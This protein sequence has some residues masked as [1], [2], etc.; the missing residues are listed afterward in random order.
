SGGA[1]DLEGQR[2]D[3]GR[4]HGQ[5]GQDVVVGVGTG[6]GQRDDDAAAG[7]VA[8]L[9]GVARRQPQVAVED[10]ELARDVGVD[11]DVV[12]GDERGRVER[13][14]DGGSRRAVVGLVGEGEA[15]EAD[16]ARLDRERGGRGA[17][18]AAAGRDGHQVDADV[19]GCVGERGRVVGREV[20]VGG[21]F[22]GGRVGEVGGDGLRLAVVSDD[23]VFHDDGDEGDGHG[24]DLGRLD[25]VAEV[26]RHADLA[27]DR[28]H[29]VG[30]GDAL[31]VGRHRERD[32]LDVGEREALGGEQSAAGREGDLV[33]RLR[34]RLAVLVVELYGQR[35]ASASG[36]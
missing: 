7:I 23:E 25:G 1:C 31:S 26:G 13:G 19:A 12:A 33:A 3:A 22:G 29:Q 27:V 2:L 36:G 17:R 10:L 15:G 32:G 28:A 35:D 14:G 11:V 4:A 21:A 24:S 8:V 5:F 16:L 34:E 30:D 6:Q 18:E 20:G 9:P